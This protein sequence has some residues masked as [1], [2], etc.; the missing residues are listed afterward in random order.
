MGRRRS[1]RSGKRRGASFTQGGLGGLLAFAPI[2]NAEGGF[3]AT[4]A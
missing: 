3:L 4:F 2:T 1:E